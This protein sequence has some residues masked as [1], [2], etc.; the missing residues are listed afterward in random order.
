MRLQLAT[1]PCMFKLLTHC[2]Y[3]LSDVFSGR[4]K[5]VTR[6]QAQKAYC[7]HIEGLHMEQILSFIKQ[8]PDV[9]EYF[10]AEEEIPKSGK[11]WV[12]NMLQTL[13]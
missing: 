13:C 5:F 12:V 11:E 8:R 4:K 9:L 10:P 2:S 3:Y 1:A 6:Q 7:P